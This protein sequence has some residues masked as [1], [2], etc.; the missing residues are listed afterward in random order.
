MYKRCYSGARIRDKIPRT[1]RTT[2]SWLHYNIMRARVC[3]GT[4]QY[5]IIFFKNRAHVQYCS[6][7]KHELSE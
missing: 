5:Y 2:H 1:F 4:T 3:V 7:N 6:D